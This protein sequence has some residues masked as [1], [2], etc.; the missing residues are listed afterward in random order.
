MIS[1]F[2]IE[3]EVIDL[4]IEECIIQNSQDLVLGRFPEALKSR[5]F[6]PIVPNSDLLDKLSDCERLLIPMLERLNYFNLRSIKL[7]EKYHEYVAYWLGIF[8]ALDP[9]VLI[10]SGTPHE[11]SNYVAYS[12]AK[13]LNVKTLIL[14][15]TIF[16]DRMLIQKDI[17][18]FQ[19]MPQN[20]SSSQKIDTDF[21]NNYQNFEKKRANESSPS[22]IRKFGEY[23]VKI[24]K[25][26]KLFRSEYDSVFGLCEHQPVLLRKKIYERKELKIASRLKKYYKKNS[27]TPDLSV[28]YLYFPLNLQPERTTLPLGKHFWNQKYVLNILL[29]SLPCG[30][31]LYIKEHPRQFSRTPLKFS[32]ARDMDFYESLQKDER[33]KFIDLAFDSQRLMESSKCIATVTGTA[34]WEAIL[35]NIPV[36]VFGYPW[37]RECPEILKVNTIKDCQRH[38]SNIAEGKINVDLTK[39]R[40]YAGWIKNESC[41]TGSL[42]PELGTSLSREENAEHIARAIKTELS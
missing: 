17:F 11:G 42:F 33:V 3:D 23:L 39:V 15:R 35:K 26:R 13:L 20:Y 30:W 34:G 1:A 37:Y 9:E 6:G 16:N 29:S 14:E 28:P 24:N 8:K 36:L 40:S 27:V 38:L 25:V 31:Q 22:L 7:I 21:L 2:N 10:F 41:H 4:S 12:L 19:K 5:G 32:M 18:L